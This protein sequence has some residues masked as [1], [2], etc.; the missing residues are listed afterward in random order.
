M[1][2]ITAMEARRKAVG[3]PELMY[4]YPTNNGVDSTTAAQLM[5][6]GGAELAARIM[7]D[8]HVGETGG[9]DCAMFDFESL[10][11]FPQSA[12]NCEYR[13]EGRWRHAVV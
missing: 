12:I 13:S 7:P 5:Q 3:A 9:V 2:T 10:P 6:L 4:M 1:A 8:C 11:S